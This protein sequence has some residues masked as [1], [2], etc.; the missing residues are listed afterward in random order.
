[1]TTQTPV[2]VL[3]RQANVLVEAVNDMIPRLDES[4]PLAMRSWLMLSAFS[5]WRGTTLLNRYDVRVLAAAICDATWDR[6][7]MLSP[8]EEI[9]HLIRAIFKRFPLP[10]GREKAIRVVRDVFPEEHVEIAK[11][12]LDASQPGPHCSF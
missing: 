5:E 1:M 3:S 8:W 7:Y 9:E 6:G 4:T 12:L 11:A 10:E 2:T